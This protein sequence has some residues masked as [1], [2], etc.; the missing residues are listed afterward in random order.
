MPP[1]NDFVNGTL[2]R[3]TFFFLRTNNRNTGL[4]FE[5]VR[6]VH[7]FG[8]KCCIVFLAR[9]IPSKINIL[10]FSSP[11]VLERERNSHTKYFGIHL[12]VVH[13]FSCSIL[14]DL[15]LEGASHGIALLLGGQV[16]WVNLLSILLQGMK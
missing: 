8:M 3:I 11:T 9:V 7:L 1:R 6:G 2:K 4:S 14:C 5:W 13:T 16:L 15:E 10:E 12:D